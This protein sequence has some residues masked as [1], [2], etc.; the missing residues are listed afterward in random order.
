MMTIMVPDI[1]DPNEEMHDK[2]V[3]IADSLHHVMDLLKAAA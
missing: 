1:L 3:H 2:C